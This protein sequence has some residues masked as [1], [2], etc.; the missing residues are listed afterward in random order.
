VNNT[1]LRGHSK[2]LKKITQRHIEK[3][4]SMPK[5]GKLNKNSVKFNLRQ[6]ET[7][8][9]FCDFLLLMA[10][11]CA[12]VFIARVIYHYYCINIYNGS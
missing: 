10:I 5:I 11:L 3:E 6:E 4:D 9:Y 2:L 12:S 8:K 1:I 7:V